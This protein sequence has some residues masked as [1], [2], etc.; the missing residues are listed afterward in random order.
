MLRSFRHH[1]ETERCH[2]RADSPQPVIYSTRF[3]W[4]PF[5]RRPSTS[6]KRRSGRRSCRCPR[7]AGAARV[8]L[9]LETLQPIGSFK[10]RGAYNAVARSCRRT[11][12]RSGVWTVSAGN[13]AQG[14]ALAAPKRP[15]RLQRASSWT[16]RRRRNCTPSSGSAR[17]IVKASV[18]RMLAHGRDSTAPNRMPGRFVHPF[19][20]DDFISGNGT[21]G[22]EIL[23]DLP[24]VDAVI[25][26]L[27]GGGLLA[28]IGLR[29]SRRSARARASTPRSRR[30]RRRCR[31]RSRPARASYVRRLDG[32]VRR[33]RGRP[34]GARRRCGRC[35]RTRVD[36][37]I[38]V[39]LDDAARGDAAGRR[40][41][42]TSSPKARRRAPLPRRCRR[43]W[44]RGATAKSWR[45]SPAAT[46]TFRASRNSSA[47][48]PDQAAPAPACRLVAGREHRLGHLAS[49]FNS[50]MRGM[51]Y[52]VTAGH[53]RRVPDAS[54]PAS[55]AGERSRG[56]PG[57]PRPARCSAGSTT[58]SGGRP[59][60]TRC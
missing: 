47:R 7:S 21:I 15:A 45:S 6:T 4:I 24:D 52:T 32:V 2:R 31:R 57:T 46:S 5:A 33:R 18:R 38:V 28:G 51:G 14:V 26:P 34:L 48:A 42:C 20:D 44:P 25:A 27:G 60:T 43:R 35:S 11:S 1:S 8:F 3:R 13:A 23:E 56:G 17:T 40:T 30:P 58:R 54:S 49:L 16:R 55:R 36:E 29:P 19:D 12:S 41:A 22:L 37:S 50:G 10:I 39:A 59:R 53:R 9:K